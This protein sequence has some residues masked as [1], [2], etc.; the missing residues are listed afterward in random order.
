MVL[1][2]RGRNEWVIDGHSQGVSGVYEESMEGN[3]HMKRGECHV[4]TPMIDA[5][6]EAVSILCNL[7][8]SML[9]LSCNKW[10]MSAQYPRSCSL[11]SDRSAGRWSLEQYV[12]I[13]NQQ[14]RAVKGLVCLRWHASGVCPTNTIFGK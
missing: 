11:A 1:R 12:Q 6:D 5:E 4:D 14:V 9:F 13:T 7:L 10:N 3:R 2:N 8:V